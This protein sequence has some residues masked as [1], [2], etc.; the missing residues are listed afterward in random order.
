MEIIM[1]ISKTI[2]KDT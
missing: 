2:L 1:R